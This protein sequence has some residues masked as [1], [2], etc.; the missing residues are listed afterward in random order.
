MD[1]FTKSIYDQSFSFDGEYL[2][3]DGF[4]VGI[5]DVSSPSE[6]AK[7]LK[8]VFEDIILESSPDE[9]LRDF[10]YLTMKLGDF[11]EIIKY[12]LANVKSE[13]VNHV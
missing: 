13:E 4:S 8:E 1:E 11:E 10:L 9:R 3:I 2:E 5:L 7:R 12:V 6:L